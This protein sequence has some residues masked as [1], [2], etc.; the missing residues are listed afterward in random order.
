MTAGTYTYYVTFESEQNGM[1]VGSVEMRI[2]YDCSPGSPEYIPSW[3]HPEAY[4]PGS[5]PEVNWIAIE[6]EP[7]GD[8]VWESAP[9]DLREW[10]MGAVDDETL[11]MEAAKED[12][13]R[14]ES[15]GDHAAEVRAELRRNK[16]PTR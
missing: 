16:A 2:R 13:T 3:E 12:E 5:A 10:A 11:A 14:R 4:D 6:Y 1:I 9:N 8:N 15:A 7:R